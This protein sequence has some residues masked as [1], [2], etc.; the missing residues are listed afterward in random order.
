MKIKQN[1]TKQEMFV[2]IQ[3][4]DSYVRNDTA[5]QFTVIAHDTIY[6]VYEQDSN[7]Y[8]GRLEQSELS[9]KLLNNPAKY[10]YEECELSDI[11]Y[12]LE[13][14]KTNRPLDLVKELLTYLSNNAGLNANIQINDFLKS[15]GLAE[16][17]I[18]N[19]LI[20]M[21]SQ[22]L[23]YCPAGRN[24]G[25][26]E[27][28]RA[29]NTLENMSISASLLKEGLDL[30]TKNYKTDSLIT[31]PA[32]PIS[33]EPTMLY[34][35]L[36][37]LDNEKYNLFGLKE[38]QLQKII[39]A[40]LNGEEYYHIAG[41]KNSFINLKTISIYS[42]DVESDPTSASQYYLGNTSFRLSSLGKHYLPSNVMLKMGKEVTYEKI[43]DKEFG[44]EN[45]SITATYTKL[46]IITKMKKIFISHSSR[47]SNYVGELINLIEG[48]GI[49]HDQIFCSSFE[50][51]GVELGED[52]LYRLKKELDEDILVFFILT[53]NFYNSPISLCEMGATWIKTN[54]HIPILIPPF[55]FK[56][57]K[58]VFPVTN[59]M[60]INDKNK[61]NSL[62]EALESDF[63]LTQLKTTIWEKKREKFLSDI[64]LQI[65]TEVKNIKQERI[66]EQIIDKIILSTDQR[67]SRVELKKIIGEEPQ[68]VLQIGKLKLKTVYLNSAYYQL[69][70]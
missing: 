12:A 68:N 59:G 47:D 49:T 65:D 14:N 8:V 26:S 53:Q 56:D 32:K 62:K 41:K 17:V 9:Q 35:L 40:Y 69:G 34:N 6:K 13:E 33:S 1:I 27:A 2:S 48:I 10:K 58:G 64:N 29:K 57:V 18:R 7:K 19:R 28:G 25:N 54:K 39:T 42:H 23:I 52:F 66:E 43:G 16:D 3:T 38:V 45:T 55:D 31:L 11:D 46:P 61:L 36:V 67:I 70:D 50:G 21:V 30:Y 51:Y 15:T 4:W 60:K 20:G 22:K 63:S 24:L 44:S 5:S 37:E